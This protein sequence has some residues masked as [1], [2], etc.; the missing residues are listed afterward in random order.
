ME[1]RKQAIAAANDPENP[2]LPPTCSPLKQSHGE[3]KSFAALSPTKAA[4]VFTV[5]GK[6]KHQKLDSSQFSNGKV[7]LSLSDFNDWISSHPIANIENNKVNSTV[8]QTNENS[9]R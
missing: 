2:A 4:F 8:I 3:G 6:S 7:S 9:K 5:N 1:L